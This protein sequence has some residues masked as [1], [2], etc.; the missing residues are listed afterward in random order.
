MFVIAISYKCFTFS[1]AHERQLA[2][3]GVR[4]LGMGDEDRAEPGVLRRVLCDRPLERRQLHQLPSHQ[5][6]P[7]ARSQEG[8]S[9]RPQSQEVRE[10]FLL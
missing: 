2:A 1:Q 8:P 3:D 4:S 10:E 7:A 6:H 9:E 5:Q